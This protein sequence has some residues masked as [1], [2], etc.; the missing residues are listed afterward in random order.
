MAQVR[1]EADSWRTRKLSRDLM[2][3]RRD[4]GHALKS[5]DAAATRAARRRVDKAKTALGERGPV[6]WND[7]APDENRRMARNTSYAEWY[8]AVEPK[9]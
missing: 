1:S 5:G 4:V 6:W 7:G 8:A 3:A 9:P 2:S